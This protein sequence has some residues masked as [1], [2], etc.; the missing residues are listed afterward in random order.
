MLSHM[1]STHCKEEN[2]RMVSL[3]RSLNFHVE[4]LRTNEEEEFG[5]VK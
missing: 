3:I 2:A 1:K 4:Y 5:I